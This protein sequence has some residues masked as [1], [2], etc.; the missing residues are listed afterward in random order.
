MNGSDP[1][2]TSIDEETMES[3]PF[4]LKAIV[5]GLGIAIIAMLGLILYKIVA[6]PAEEKAVPASRPDP[7][8]AEQ[9][10]SLAG[11]L[12]TDGPKAQDFDIAVPEGAT[13]VSTVPAGAEVFLH[14][15]LADGTDQVLILN[16]VTGDISRLWVKP[17]GN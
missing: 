10:E 1:K 8:A 16:R 11:R 13:L 2:V 3:A 9:L 6:G 14:V 12:W 17:E 5:V 7:I 4:F 15:R